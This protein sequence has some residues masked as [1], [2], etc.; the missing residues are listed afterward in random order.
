MNK[1]CK[2][3]LIVFASIALVWSFLFIILD[4]RLLFS[5]DWIVYDSPLFGFF[6]Y[7]SRFLLSVF[8]FTKSLFEII[9][10]KRKEEF[11]E[12]L[13]YADIS[14]IIMSIFALIFTANFM[15]LICI[16]LSSVVL[17]IK[18]VDKYLLKIK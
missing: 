9:K 16:V 11:K 17:G 4:G 10:H 12:Y 7:L 5:G 18:L 2:I 14:L 13:L 8:A 3:L 1:V 6:K 15:G